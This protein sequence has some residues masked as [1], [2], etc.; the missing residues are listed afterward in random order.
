MLHV[1]DPV[2]NGLR[3]RFVHISI[4]HL[5]GIQLDSHHHRLGFFFYFI[6]RFNIYLFSSHVVGWHF[7][8]SLKSFYKRI[9][10]FT[11]PFIALHLPSVYRCLRP[12]L[13]CAVNI[14]HCHYLFKCFDAE[15]Q[16]RYNYYYYSAL[17]KLCADPANKVTWWMLI[18]Y[19]LYPISMQC[20][21][22][23][24][25]AHLINKHQ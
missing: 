10:W 13:P 19:I 21:C 16:Q 7:T 20:S 1:G 6:F 2:A 8:K 22:I 12:D 9:N 18:N 11:R 23:I 17:Q 25:C 14:K 15:M 3:H 4:N 5:T 24:K